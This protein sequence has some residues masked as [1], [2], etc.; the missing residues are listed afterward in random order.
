MTKKHFIDL[1]DVLRLEILPQLTTAQDRGIVLDELA[2]FC[3]R[4]NP[5]FNRERWTGYIN[6]QC[7]PNG[8]CIK[9]A[10]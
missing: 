9:K 5:R 10:A 2:A 1:A 6:G 8:G 3:A 7:G 4:Q